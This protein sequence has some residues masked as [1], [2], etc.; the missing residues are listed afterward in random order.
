MQ[1]DDTTHNSRAGAHSQNT[2]ASTQLSQVY[3][4]ADLHVSDKQAW[5]KTKASALSQ[6]VAHCG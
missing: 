5:G 4:Q 6:T 1:S 2:H 3:I